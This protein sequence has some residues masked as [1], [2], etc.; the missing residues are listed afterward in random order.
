MK[1]FINLK[2][3]RKLVLSFILIALI[4]G[5]MG[6]YAIYNLK[7][8]EKSDTELYNNM[9]VPLSEIGEISS[10]FQEI[11]VDIR[12]IILAQTPEEMQAEINSIEQNR[13]SVDKLAEVFGKTLVT[14]D[15]KK[16][17]EE[18]EAARIAFRTAADKV[19]ELAKQNRDAEAMQMMSENG[20][21]GKASKA[22]QDSIAKLVQ[23]KIDDA[24]KKSD[25]NSAGANRTIAVMT[26]VMAIVVVLSILIGLLISSIITRPLKKA[27]HMLEEMSL[28][29]F[30]N[31]L[32][33]GTKDEIGQ[34]ANTMDSFADDLQT[35]V[36]GVMNLI[37]KG[38]TSIEISVKDD[39]DE[40]TPALKKTVET[41]RDLNTE[42]NKLIQ[43]ATEGK[44]DVRGDSAGYSGAWQDMISGING[45]IDAF[46]APINVTAEYVERISKGD[47]PP[48]IT[49]TYLG[50]F[51]EIKNNINNCIDVMK[52][53]LGETDLLI[54]GV[55]DGKLDIRGNADQFNGDWG[56]MVQGINDLIDAFVA[57]INMTAEYVDRISKGD[58]PLRITDTYYGDFNEIKNNINGCIDVMNG[59][60]GET[61][62][63]I[64]AA[65]D[66]E[67]DI[68]ANSE[69]FIGDWGVLMTGI[70]NLVDAFVSPINMTAEYVDRISKGDIPSKI[71][72]EYHGDFNEIKNNLNNCID[73]MNG[74]QN[75][76]NGLIKAAQEGKLDV[77]ADSSRF[78]G[79]WEELISGVNSLVEAV[80]KPIK[81]VTAVM[82]E[83]A[84]GNLKIMVKG[85]YQGEFGVLSNS[86]N[87]TVHD[88]N[89][90][91]GEI[92][93][94]IG[95]ISE[96]NLTGNRVNEFK[97]DFISISN[98][99]NTILESLNVVLGD[100]N[101]A[102]DQVTIGSKQVSDGSQALSQGT[103]EQ[104]SS[105]EELTASINEVAGKT[106]ENA[107]NAGEASSLTLTVKDNAE[108]GNSHMKQMLAA[109]EEI[110]EASNNI[111]KIIKVIDD[112]AFQTNILAL[113]A[114]VE[115]ARA[116]QHGKGFAVVAEEVRTLAAR[117]AEAAKETTDLIQ[118]SMKKTS[119]G[120]EIANNTAK[121]L[122]QIVDGVAKTADIIAGIAKSSNEQAMGIAQIN[123]GLTQVSQVVQNNA[124]TAEESAASSEELS[125]QAE[126]LKEMVGKFRLRKMQSLSGA[127]VK[128]LGASR[129]EKTAQSSVPK[130]IM[131]DFESDK[132]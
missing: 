37:S 25:S 35:K 40:I 119:G 47:I 36:I 46:V 106:K 120:T 65:Q 95:E 20:E 56:S 9:T 100:I 125:G 10:D 17:F 57:P 131:G 26:V 28:G 132:Y 62:K 41:I 67:L 34:M 112:I 89:S 66:G 71:T 114:A 49:D 127:E 50:D 55:K 82:N 54:K 118:G 129:T 103:T 51:N 52:K 117:S 124:A 75:E 14:D 38:D 60:L 42:V 101:N 43:A 21:S 69:L 92:S 81:E 113:N 39:K 73:I 6:G 18:S 97:G 58:I 93:E 11:R 121:A 96:G 12:D 44:L 5:A 64:N 3:G 130:I 87:N 22:Y 7:V 94:V 2:I 102:A 78:T 116:G 15:E 24:K 98:S 29:H 99:L 16:I 13:D 45:L 8:I 23:M 128:L 79:G 31:R 63:L 109:M 104:A 107:V 59:L 76:M 19:I 123:T 84:Q 86:V 30:G 85:D 74:L 1:W 83:I 88:L 61:K 77:R 108:Q 115:A 32:K 53:L 33:L 126:V 27:V 48:L 70:N 111:S 90:V 4:C 110:N 91:V 72:E 80:V 105:L 68:R 122:D